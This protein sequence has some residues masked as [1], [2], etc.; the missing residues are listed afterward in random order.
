MEVGGALGLYQWMDFRRILG[1]HQ[2]R[3]RWW[4]NNWRLKIKVIIINFY[5]IVFH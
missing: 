1:A 5:C 4:A 2:R 3:F